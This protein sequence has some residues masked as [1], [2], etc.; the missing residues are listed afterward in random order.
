MNKVNPSYMNL[1]GPNYNNYPMVGTVGDTRLIL[2]KNG[3]Y[4]SKGSPVLEIRSALD[5][6][7]T[8]IVYKTLGN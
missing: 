1:R 2:R 3:D 8:R 5:P 4:Y 7:Y 6:L